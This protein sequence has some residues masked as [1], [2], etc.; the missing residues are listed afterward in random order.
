[1]AL[2]PPGHSSGLARSW[3]VLLSPHDRSGVP[4]GQRNRADCCAQV[5]PECSLLVRPAP[6]G[7][8]R[9]ARPRPDKDDRDDKDRLLRYVWVERE[10][11]GLPYLLNTKMVREGYATFN[12]K[13][14]NH[15]YDDR[16]QVAEDQ[17]KEAEAGLWGTYGGNHVAIVPEPELGSGDLPAPLGTMLTVDGQEIT[18][19]DAF[20]SYDYGFSTPQ[21]GYVFLVFTATIKN[22]DDDDHGY[23]DARFSARDLDTEATFDDTFTLADQPLGSGELS[24]GEFVFGTVVL[25]VQDTSQRVRIKYDAK[26]IGE[27]EVYWLVLR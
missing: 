5:W 3:L 18:V 19:S 26:F 13:G 21:G 1:M 6:A 17:A 14:D 25:E 9:L 2:T 12:P 15:R 8:P 7:E 24:P 22:V 11:A 23:D 27:G 20:F 4:T 10:G 16:L